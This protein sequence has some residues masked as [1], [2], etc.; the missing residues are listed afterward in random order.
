MA[1][2]LG[3]PPNLVY[4]GSDGVMLGVDREELDL[5]AVS[6]RELELVLSLMIFASARV[7]RELRR[8]SSG[9]T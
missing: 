7:R 5:T 6:A 1:E 3:P 9:G 2:E 8:R 4:Y